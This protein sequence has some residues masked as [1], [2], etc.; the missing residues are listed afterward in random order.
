M[1]YNQFIQRFQELGCVLLTTDD[2]FRKR[3]CDVK[4]FKFDVRCSCGHERKVNYYKFHKAKNHQCKACNI[5][6]V[7]KERAIPYEIIKENFEKRGCVL[8]TTKEDYT[9]NNNKTGEF[10]FDFTAS[11]GHDR[12]AKYYV[13]L[14][15]SSKC[16]ECIR[17]ELNKTLSH[18]SRFTF[19]QVKEVFESFGC[20]LET[21][22]EEYDAAECVR[23]FKFKIIAKCGCNHETKID[24]FKKTKHMCGSCSRRARN[25]TEEK[26]N[27]LAE[28]FTS[29]GCRLLTTKDEYIDDNM[30][31]MSP[32]RFI[33]TCGCE[34]TSVLN[35]IRFTNNNLKCSRCRYL[36]E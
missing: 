31:K 6:Q 9:Q 26:Y 30:N 33:A 27:E 16:L 18:K 14:D 35:N 29:I 12:K 2:D 3:E 17:S 11:C 4:Q 25:N 22:K 24:D 1:S 7:S 32:F 8:K 19:D 5:A 13:F 34:R 15:G 10:V 23:N 36:H 21:S 28:K 20:R